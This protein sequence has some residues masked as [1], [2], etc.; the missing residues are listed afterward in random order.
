MNTIIIYN[1]NKPDILTI[2]YAIKCD[3]GM[4]NN[5]CTNCLT[6][7][8]GRSDRL[9]MLTCFLHDHSKHCMKHNKC[10]N[11][12]HNYKICNSCDNCYY[13]YNTLSKCYNCGYDPSNNPN[14]VC[15]YRREYT[16]CKYC[17]KKYIGCYS[18]FTHWFCK[19]T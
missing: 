12:S 18:S 17:K 11:N 16:K 1:M 19:F 13:S 10:H 7:S 4:N 6:T 9:C 5:C 2:P 14:N 3:D 8:I 15:Y